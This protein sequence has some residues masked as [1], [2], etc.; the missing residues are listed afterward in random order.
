MFNKWESVCIFIHGMGSL[1]FCHLRDYL[2]LKF[3]SCG[4]VSKNVLYAYVMKRLFFSDAFK[5]ICCDTGLRVSSHKQ[6]ISIPCGVFKKAVHLMFAS[7][8]SSSC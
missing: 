8:S 3:F 2:R 4:M 5:E 1:D 6:F 7:S